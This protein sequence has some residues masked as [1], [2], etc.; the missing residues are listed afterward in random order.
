MN[1]L[2]PDGLTLDENEEIIVIAPDVFKRLGPVLKNTTKRTI[3]NNF[4]WRTVLA[5]SDFLSEDI[6][7]KKNAFFRIVSGQEETAPR[8]KECITY[9]STA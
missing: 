7:R 6:R 8:W 9:T 3:A 1:A 2:M 4:M 5:A